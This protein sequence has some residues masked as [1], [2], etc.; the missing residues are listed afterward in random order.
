MVIG[1]DKKLAKRLVMEIGVTWEQASFIVGIIA[2]E[3]QIADREGNIRGYND[4]YARAK[5][6]FDKPTNV[7]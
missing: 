6:K 2:E 3:R 7:S 5:E 1:W 4:G